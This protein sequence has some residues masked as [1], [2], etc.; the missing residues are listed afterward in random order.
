MK[1]RHIVVRNSVFSSLPFHFISKNMTW[2]VNE[3]HLLY[4]R[5]A[6][7]FIFFFYGER[8]GIELRDREIES[9]IETYLIA[10]IMLE[11]VE[12]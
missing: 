2:D 3:F 6:R 11:F 4:M 8:G 5:I 12:F 10:D 7:A 1:A 9:M